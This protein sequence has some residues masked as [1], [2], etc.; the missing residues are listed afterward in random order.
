MSKEAMDAFIGTADWYASLSNTF[1][2]MF[3]VEKP[4]HVLPKFSL[5]ILVMQEVAYHIL[6]GF[7]SILHQKKKA[8]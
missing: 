3:S 5:D 6:V 8:S 1:I 2:R 4:P 7:T